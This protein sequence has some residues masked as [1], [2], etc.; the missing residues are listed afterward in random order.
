M[1]I[2]RRVL[3]CAIVT[4]TAAQRYTP[5]PTDVGRVEMATSCKPEAQAHF[6]RGAALLHSFW[7]DEALKAFEQ[8]AEVDPDCGMAYWGQAMTWTHP[9]WDPP[10][11]L[12]VG[13]GLEASRR[14]RAVGAPTARERGY[15]E[16][17]ALLYEHAA[18]VPLKA[19]LERYSGAMAGVR[20]R[21]PGDKNAVAFYALSLLSV[22][23]ATQYEKD[24][25]AARLLE[26][27]FGQAPDHPG[28]AHYLIHACDNPVH[29]PKGLPAA[30]KYARIAPAIPHA[31][32]MP[33]HIYTR[34]GMWEKS[35]ASNEAAW[36]ASDAHVSPEMAHG[37][38]R[39]YHSLQWLLYAYLQQGRFKKAGDTLALVHEHA[40]AEDAAGG[41]H[42]DSLGA[43]YHYADMAARYALER[44][45]WSE[46]MAAPG[47][48][49]ARHAQ[50]TMWYARG[51]GAARAAWPGGDPDKIRI[52][53]EAAGK[54]AAVPDRPGQEGVAE[55]ERL[56]VLAAI[57]GAQE[58]REEMALL[59]AQAAAKED[60]I[61]TP[62]QPSYPV[63]PIH[64]VAGDLWM[65]VNRYAD[66]RREYQAALKRFPRRAR[67]LIGLAR[68]SA[69]AGDDRSARRAYTELLEMWK[70]VDADR[71]EIAEARAYLR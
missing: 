3:A 37:G 69:K 56:A 43:T 9:L 16:A 71:P 61:F 34:L 59:L 68:A 51:L 62:G 55:I 22:P 63:I 50:G 21:N 13:R 58:E 19:R 38:D 24:L 15:I 5:P 60:A 54:L 8:A 70:A 17:L 66:A 11:S 4:A 53:R 33:A 47:G 7:Y 39:D 36:A 12:S 28:A 65:Q 23:G 64:E 48:G 2:S 46:A 26:S 40:K 67:A 49:T 45:A 30:D 52:A 44:G 1:A 27:V 32:H 57:A 42:T 31:L 18:S 10:S 25:Q 29:A 41:A 6:E 14:A 35:A 20:A